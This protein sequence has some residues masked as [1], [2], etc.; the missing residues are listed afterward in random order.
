MVLEAV[1]PADA[2][3]DLPWLEAKNFRGWIKPQLHI[4]DGVAWLLLSHPVKAEDL[5]KLDLAVWRIV[6]HHPFT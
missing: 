1:A 4:R 6:T 3:A 2:D 5:H